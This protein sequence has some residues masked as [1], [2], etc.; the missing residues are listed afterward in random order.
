MGVDS[1][2]ILVHERIGLAAPQSNNDPI[3]TT[4][5]PETEEEK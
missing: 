3:K 5:K 1:E 2:G 4:F